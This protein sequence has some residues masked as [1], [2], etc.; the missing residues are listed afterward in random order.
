V[1]TLGARASSKRKK[2]A[3]HDNTN[4]TSYNRLGDKGTSTTVV[5]NQAHALVLAPLPQLI[6]GPILDD[7]IYTSGDVKADLRYIFAFL[8]NT[9]MNFKKPHTYESLSVKPPNLPKRKCDHRI[10][11]VTPL[12]YSTINTCI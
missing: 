6:Q 12:N 7:V 8:N 4:A 1:V 2:V 11:I 5:I 3:I 10:A 9:C